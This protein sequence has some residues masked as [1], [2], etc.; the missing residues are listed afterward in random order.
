MNPYYILIVFL[1]AGLGGSLRHS[2]GVL[3]KQM[4]DGEFPVGTF[5]V[6]VTGSFVMGVLAGYFALKGEASLEWRLFLTTGL[7]GGYTTFSAFSLE[8][9]LLWERGAAVMAVLYIVGSV[10]LAVGGFF[11]GIWLVRQM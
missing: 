11:S 10:V 1:G 7:L 9:V 3:A 5:S 6:N 8:S 2:V 4:F